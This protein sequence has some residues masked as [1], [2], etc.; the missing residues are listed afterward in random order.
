MLTSLIL[1]ERVRTTLTKARV[2]RSEADSLIARA[3][4]ND[5][6]AQRM[7]RS[8]LQSKEAAAK[9]FDVLIKRYEHRVGGCTQV[10]KLG[11]RLSD[12]ADLAIVKLLS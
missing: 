8:L 10:F 12:N 2:L 9:M 5:H 3:K 7:V 6:R 4:C 1:H 11:K